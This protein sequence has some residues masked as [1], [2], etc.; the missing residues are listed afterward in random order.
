MGTQVLQSLFVVRMSLDRRVYDI[1]DRA[2]VTFVD[3]VLIEVEH[4]SLRG[5]S[6]EGT[7]HFARD[8]RRLLLAMAGALGTDPRL[9]DR[10]LKRP[11][12]FPSVASLKSTCC[13]KKRLR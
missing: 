9:T 12:L 6:L 8:R 11:R 2:L 3:S 7:M 5:C 1:V 10:S 4:P 13:S